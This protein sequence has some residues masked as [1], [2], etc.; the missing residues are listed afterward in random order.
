MGQLAGRQVDVLGRIDGEQDAGFA[1][2]PVTRMLLRSDG[3]TTR[4]L[5]ALLDQALSVQ[6]VDQHGD[7]AGALPAHLREVLGCVADEAVVRR[8]SVLVTADATQVSRNEVTVVCRDS[9]LTSI[10][11]D[12]STPIGHGLATA[13]R[14]LGRIRMSTGST[15]W[16]DEIEIPCVYKEYVL[17]DPAGRAIAHVYERFNPDYVP[18]GV[19]A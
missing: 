14:M 1:L 5:E 3:S 17:V 11:T 18:H 19:A 6:L 7:T 2:P 16:A 8:R 9:E 12:A 4:L 13:R 15:R 10:L